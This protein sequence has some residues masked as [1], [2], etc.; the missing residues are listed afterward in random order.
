MISTTIVP[1][2]E[3][4][5]A[6][7]PPWELASTAAGVAILMVVIFL[8]FIYRMVSQQAAATKDQRDAQAKTDKEQRD[9]QAAQVKEQREAHA[10]EMQA[11][12]VLFTQTLV[13]ITETNAASA[14]RVETALRDLAMELRTGTARPRGVVT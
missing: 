6:A 4:V 10:S 2:L 11:Q 1:F 8:G 5:P 7:D 14:E 12:R 3:Q 13:Q 9:A